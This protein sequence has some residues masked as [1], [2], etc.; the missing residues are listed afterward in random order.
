MTKIAGSGYEPGSG[1]ISQRLG[2]EDPGP[3]QNV[4]DPATLE[5]NGSAFIVISYL[6][7]DPDN[8]AKYCGEKKS[9]TK[10]I[11]KNMQK[12]SNIPTFL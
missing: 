5:Q 2:S 10:V 4:M 1:S 6:R 7:V 3:Y 12:L 9:T 11:L 8:T